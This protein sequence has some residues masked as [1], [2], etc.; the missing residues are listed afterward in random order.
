MAYFFG[1]EYFSVNKWVGIINKNYSAFNIKFKA[2]DVH[3]LFHHF[4][5][6][7]IENKGI[8]YYSVDKFNWFSKSV[9]FVDILKNINEYG[10]AN[11]KES[12]LNKELSK[13]KRLN[14]KND[15]YSFNDDNI[16]NDMEKYSDYLINDKYQFEDKKIKKIIV[17]ESTFN[18]LFENVFD[19]G[20]EWNSDGNGNI[21]LSINS[22][23]TDLDNKEV[24]TRIFGTKHD[25]LYGDNTLGGN[26]K[27]LSK[28]YNDAVKRKKQY[29]TI[30][31]YAKN[32]FNGDL[33][34][35]SQ[36]QLKT[37]K[38]F[39][40]QGD[41]EGMASWAEAR[42]GN[43][44]NA[45]DVNNYTTNKAN[46]LEHDDTKMARYKKMKVRGTNV[47]VIALYVMNDFNFS[48]ALKNG[49]VRQNG[50]TDKF[51]GISKDQRERE[52]GIG[53]TPL[54][55]LQVTYDD[56]QEFN[57][58]SNF[59]LDLP[60]NQNSRDHFKQNFHSKK[61]YNSI[62][63]FLDKSIIYAKYALK[64]ESFIPDYIVSAP[65]SSKFNK[66]YCI[67]LS[68]KLGVPYIENFFK[69]NLINIQFDEELLKKQPLSEK[70]EMM[71]KEDIKKAMY[72]EIAS[73]VRMPVN[74]FVKQ[75]WGAFASIN[76]KEYGRDKIEEQLI[77]DLLNDHIYSSILIT[78]GQ[79]A[80]NIFKTLVSQASKYINNSTKYDAKHILEKIITITKKREIKPYFLQVLQEVQQ[81][82]MSY[83]NK[84]EQGFSINATKF[85]IA[86]IQQRFRHYL[87]NVYVICDEALNKDKNLLTRYQ[88]AKY[89]IF[90]EDINSGATLKLVIDALQEKTFGKQN[91]IMC[92][93]NAYSASGF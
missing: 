54:K 42:I 57:L 75:F 51:L 15:S 2:N 89:L 12:F 70:D 47:D 85:K 74:K 73:E 10:D 40:S 76:L 30:L 93:V 18:R 9:G 14:N 7:P 60:S 81:I 48:D 53:K 13:I 63:Q 23:Q 90:D 61:E 8:K 11:G 33:S 19:E 80:S 72:G 17:K 82:L 91:N 43:S 3:H 68:N 78:E 29:Q 86:R 24:D 55:K 34:S 71:L 16:E 65:S 58:K 69:R 35:L 31:N 77:N 66:Y 37:V 88:D 4:R 49:Y 25:I 20:V 22:R 59:S 36:S 41:A 87:N 44:Q 92:L 1:K 27:T 84:I 45:I 39:E 28:L 32:G 38:E 46:N 5:I 52:Q 83:T 6:E 67:N 21:N 56:G 26:N 62:K 79:N 64:E 50:M